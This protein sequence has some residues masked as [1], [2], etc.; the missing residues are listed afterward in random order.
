[1]DHDKI[2]ITTRKKPIVDGVIPVL[3]AFYD[4]AYLRKPVFFNDF[5]F[6]VSDP[7][8]TCCQDYFIDEL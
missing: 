1:M 3:T 6:T 8:F 4:A 7:V 2:R 5:V